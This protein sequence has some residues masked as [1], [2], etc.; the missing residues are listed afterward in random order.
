[1]PNELELEQ[2]EV[3]AKSDD[4]FSF[5]V[6]TVEFKWNE[7]AELTLQI[8]DLKVKKGEKV[9]VVGES[10]SG[11]STL[12]SLLSGVNKPQHGSVTVLGET[13]SGK[14]GSIDRFRADHIGYIFQDFNLLSYLSVIDNVTLPLHFSKKRRGRVNHPRKEAKRLLGDLGMGKLLHKSVSQLSVGQ[15]QR[16][17]V[18]RALIGSPEIILADEPTSALDKE[19]AKAF[20]KLLFEECEKE[21]ITLV[22]VSHDESCGNLFDRIVRMQDGK[23]FS[24]GRN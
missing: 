10:G 7:N 12:M 21:N 20:I 24:E 2:V 19:N 1:M 4:Q 17:A 11:K 9:F 23:V 5:S 22:F 8:P 15:C 6:D 14:G 16:V 13:L 18:A 3:K